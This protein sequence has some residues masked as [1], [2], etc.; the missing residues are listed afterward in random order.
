MRFDVGKEGLVVRPRFYMM[1]Y[2]VEKIE[3]VQPPSLRGW[4]DLFLDISRL[5]RVKGVGVG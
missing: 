5:S 4:S 3:Y 1:K 2:I